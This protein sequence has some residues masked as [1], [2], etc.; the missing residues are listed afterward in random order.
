MIRRPPRSTRTDTLFPYTT[1]FRSY[2][3]RVSG[4]HAGRRQGRKPDDT[5]GRGSW[6]NRGLGG[7]TSVSA[8]GSEIADRGICGQSFWVDQECR[9]NVLPAARIHT[10]LE[11]AR[12]DGRKSLL[13]GKMVS[14]RVVIGGTVIINKKKKKRQ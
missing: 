14:V 2:D 8:A 1:L 13:E 12:M 6:C 10:G 9:R 7:C 11:G 4:V 3:D 5:I